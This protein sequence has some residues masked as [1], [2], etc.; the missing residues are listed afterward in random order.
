MQF[1]KRSLS[2][3]NQSDF[4]STIGF[5]VCPPNGHEALRIE[6]YPF[7]ISESVVRVTDSRGKTLMET[8]QSRSESL[9]CLEY[10]VE[11]IKAGIYFFEV[12]DGFYYQVK[13]VRVPAA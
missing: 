2:L 4:R 11:D 13:E 1:R 7:Q 9:S 5:V 12:S 6:L 8:D 10:T 3:A